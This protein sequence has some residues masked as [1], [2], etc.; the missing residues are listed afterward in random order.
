ME[1]EGLQV[2]VRE[3]AGRS[4]AKIQGIEPGKAIPV[5]DHFPFYRFQPIR[6]GRKGGH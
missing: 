6:N 5:E 3:Q 1:E 2:A 4:P